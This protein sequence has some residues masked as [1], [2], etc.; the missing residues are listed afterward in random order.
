MRHSL[1]TLLA[2]ALSIPAVL[3][4][5]MVTLAQEKGNTFD[6]STLGIALSWPESLVRIEEKDTSKA[7][8]AALLLRFKGGSLPTFNVLQ[9]PG[10]F[11]KTK[12]SQTVV[13]SYHSVGLTD[14]VV[15]AS[16]TALQGWPVI[17]LRFKGKDGTTTHSIVT[18]IPRREYHL[19]LTF[20]DSEER[21]TADR[22]FLESIYASIKVSSDTPEESKLHS[23]VADSTPN[24]WIVI[25]LTAIIAA[26]VT[27]FVYRRRS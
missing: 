5:T 13:D 18:I 19:I 4:S 23:G 1:I 26:V 6:S 14:A 9:V 7:P 10:I 27:W 17:E 8:Q 24:I 11:D 22:P 21:I 25:T 15:A 12:A 16:S 20:I 3:G 2:V